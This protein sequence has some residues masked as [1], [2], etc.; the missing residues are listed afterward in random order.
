MA[1]AGATAMAA[2]TSEAEH[3]A[4]RLVEAKDGVMQLV[5]PLRELPLVQ[6]HALNA[7][8][9][10]V[11]AAG[12]PFGRARRDA[13]RTH[14]IAGDAARRRVAGR[15]RLFGDGEGEVSLAAGGAQALDHHPG[16][17]VPEG[18]ASRRQ[19][20]RDGGRV[21]R[22]RSFHCTADGGCARGEA[23]GDD[24]GGGGGGCRARI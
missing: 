8:P 11:Q 9:F 10:K 2:C 16:A 7:Q 23:R 12:T 20:G 4:V 17:G 18:S 6:V 19:V 5:V 14:P 3:M 24:D 15:Q 1:N 13:Y 22:H 21:G